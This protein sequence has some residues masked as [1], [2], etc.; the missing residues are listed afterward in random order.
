MAV[1]SQTFLLTVSKTRGE[2]T[3]HCHVVVMN[4]DRFATKF[5]LKC[6]CNVILLSVCHVHI[7][8]IYSSDPKQKLKNSE[9][10]TE[11]NMHKH[12]I[13]TYHA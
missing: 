5:V 2:G 6:K 4:D 7:Y 10:Q 11:I 9:E 12:Y 1:I 3:F 13:K 8:P